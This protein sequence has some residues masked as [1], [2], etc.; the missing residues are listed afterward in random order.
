MRQNIHELV[1][2][3]EGLGVFMKQTYSWDNVGMEYGQL[4]SRTLK[5]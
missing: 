5:S 4:E 2:T 1:R 3:K